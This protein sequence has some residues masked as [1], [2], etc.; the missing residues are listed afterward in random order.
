M[1]SPYTISVNRYF[2]VLFFCILSTQALAADSK[3]RWYKVETNSEE[4]TRQKGDDYLYDSLEAPDSKPTFV[5]LGVWTLEN[6][7]VLKGG[8]HADEKF[9]K[10]DK[11]NRFLGGVGYRFFQR[12]WYRISIEGNLIQNNSFIVGGAW[13][14]L[15]S[16][17]PSRFYYGA[18]ISH[19]LFA[20]KEF[21][22]F[23]EGENYFVTG[24][25]GWE[26]LMKSKHAW[27]LEA[28]FYL[29]SGTYAHQISASYI[30]PL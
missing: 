29:T 13:E 14:Y 8:F 16:R 10:E 30:I 4:K 21:R 11:S 9:L 25:V 7:L 15:P 6:N 28:K 22:N 3:E 18:G 19:L 1:K 23:V 12:A 5:D 20:D 24:H 2:S 17:K 27:A 26:N